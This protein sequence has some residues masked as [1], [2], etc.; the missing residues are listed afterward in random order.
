[1]AEAKRKL[2]AI[3]AAD[4]AGYSRLMGDDEEATIAILDV[5][6][7]V[8][9]D[10]IAAHD[11]RVVDTAGDSVLARFDSVVEAVRCAVEVQDELVNANAELADGRR[12][13]FR[14]G[15]NVGDVVEK[16]DGTI[17]GDGVNIAA[18]LESL[19]EPGAT[20]VSEDA[21]RQVAGKIDL[22]FQDIGE[23]HV[24]NIARPIRAFRLRATTAPMPASESDPDMPVLASPKI[25]VL[26]FSNMGGDPE[27][28]FFVDGVAEDIITRLARFPN[29]GVIA[30]NSSFKFKGEAVDV[31]AVGKDLGATYVLEGSVRRFEHRIR[32]T[33]QLLTASDGTHLWAETYDRD[34]TAGD[35][36]T[37]QD[38]ITARVVGAVA[39][40]DGVLA[41]AALLRTADRAPTELGSY[42]CVLKANEFFRQVTPETH[43]EARACLSRVV[44]HEPRYAEALASLSILTN[45]EELYGFNPE[46]ELDPPL[47]RA[48]GLARD[49]VAADPT[50]ALGHWALA[51]VSYFRGDLDLFESAADRA[52]ALAPNDTIML[53]GAG[54]HLAY[55]GHWERGLSLIDRAIALNP[56]HQSWYFF[57]RFYDAY[58]RG[59][60]D[61]ALA[62]ANRINM[63][64]YFWTYVLL[65]A[66]YAQL[67]M[68]EDASAAIARLRDLYPG[69]SVEIMISMH[70]QWQHSDD[71]IG[72][73]VEGLTK[74][75][76][77]EI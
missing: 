62:I 12:M 22:D 66:V 77:P 2:A 24:K 35:V 47:D 72:R 30:R 54:L 45:E 55:V 26:P 5:C 61:E 40:S 16:D 13:K 49:A 56:H 50:S 38:D 36:F 15:I 48:L 44:A 27:Q 58:R 42:E 37:I 18:R 68:L 73:M 14:I 11:G 21:Q 59:K 20:V 65:S 52:L 69:Y 64:D 53:A 43:L 17:Y 51:R 3:L 9:R 71:V 7:E 60:D 23:H 70:R 74:A 19:A 10:R 46:P 32:V 39:S 4:V 75:G 33:A 31:R 41:Q 29:I 8:F 34:L 6:R 76:L 28:E 63:P 25:A 1:M 67:D 57:P